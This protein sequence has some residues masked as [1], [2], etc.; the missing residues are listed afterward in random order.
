LYAVKCMLKVI[1]D[2]WSADREPILLFV[3]SATCVKK[4][5]FLLNTGPLIGSLL[6]FVS[7]VTRVKSIS[8]C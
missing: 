3:R 2:V 1:E 4:H 5:K 8:F 7:G 6:L